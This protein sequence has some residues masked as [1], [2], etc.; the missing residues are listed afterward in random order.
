MKI[1]ILPYLD[2]NHK[3]I[4]MYKLLQ[5]ILNKSERYIIIHYACTSNHYFILIKNLFSNLIEI[6][7]NKTQVVRCFPYP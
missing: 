3:K 2:A 4:H 7:R 5:M 1:L 6:N